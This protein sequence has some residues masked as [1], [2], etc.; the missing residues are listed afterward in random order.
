VGLAGSDPR[1]VAVLSEWDY[2]EN[3]KKLVGQ[4]PRDAKEQTRKEKTR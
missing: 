4:T 1:T 2:Q 3:I